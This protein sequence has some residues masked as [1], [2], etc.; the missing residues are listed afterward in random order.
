M[1]IV[2]INV[3]ET[4]GSYRKILY[5]CGTDL[6]VLFTFYIGI[7][8]RSR[9]LCRLSFFCTYRI[10]FLAHVKVDGMPQGSNSAFV[11]NV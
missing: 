5:F 2:T 3:D 4:A 10:I 6:Y 9:D 7:Y 1:Y 11:R 8:L